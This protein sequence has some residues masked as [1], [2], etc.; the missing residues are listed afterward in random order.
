LSGF[1]SAPQHLN[2]DGLYRDVN[3]DGSLTVADVQIFFTRQ[4]TVPVAPGGVRRYALSAH[5]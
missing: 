2:G 3:G 4:R 1:E 5:L